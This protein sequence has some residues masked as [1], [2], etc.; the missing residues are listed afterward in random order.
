[1][2]IA[3]SKTNVRLSELQVGDLIF[4]Y[5][6]TGDTWPALKKGMCSHVAICTSASDGEATIIHEVDGAQMKGTHLTALNPTVANDYKSTTAAALIRVLRCKDAT[7][8]QTAAMLALSWNKFLLPFGSE[9]RNRA[10]LHEGH[11]DAAAGLVEEH[12]R[13]F[14]L[15]GKYR[16]VKYA[17]R[18][19]GFLCYP[20][21]NE[22]DGIG[23]FCS[24]F[25]TICYQVAGL[26][27]AVDAVFAMDGTLRV[28]DKRMSE[29]DVA[30]VKKAFKGT[31][32]DFKE[33]QAYAAQ[34]SDKDPYKLADTAGNPKKVPPRK[35]VAY[36]PSILLWNNSKGPIQSFAWAQHITL[37]MKV[38]CKVIMPQGLFESLVQDDDGWE[39]KGVLVGKLAKDEFELQK[40][41]TQQF[42]LAQKTASD[43]KRQLFSK[44]PK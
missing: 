36:I 42:G 27:D 8:A 26:L 28:C 24:Q 37:G 43:A 15:I 34:L 9:A 7:L 13:L 17:G 23:L 33:F 29:L 1:M 30:E 40:Q 4:N 2:P 16:A 12:R 38:D 35:G 5:T 21:D 44:P 32:F 22:G 20:T 6:G 41:K 39:D 25:V 10:T 14:D 18:R 3:L 31:D 11:F 19:A